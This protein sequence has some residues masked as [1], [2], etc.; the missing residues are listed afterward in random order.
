MSL[1]DRRKERSDEINSWTLGR[2]EMSNDMS[3]EDAC[4]AKNRQE[5][6]GQVV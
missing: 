5:P 1:L 6:E 4:M 3:H 2:W